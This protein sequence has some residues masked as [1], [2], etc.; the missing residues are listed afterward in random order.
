MKK[1]LYALLAATVVL[2]AF[3][4]LNNSLLFAEARQKRPVLLAHRGMAQSFSR[5]GL[6]NDTCTATRIF[7]PEHA[8]L[9]NTIASM[10]AAFDAGADIVE[11]DVQPTT[12]GAFAVFHDWTVDC[13]TEGKGVTREHSLAQLKALDVGYGYTADGGKTFPF[14]GKGVG[15]MPSL[16]E[17]LT[18]FPDKRFLI[19]IK[20]ND[21]TEGN[22][23]A[24]RLARLPPGQR[25]L[26][27]VYGAHRPI[28]ALH[29]RLP[30]IPVGSK[31]T[32]KSCIIRY[33]AVGWT[34]YVPESCREGI[35]LVP[36]NVA[37]WMWGWPSRYLERMEKANVNVFVA[38][39]Y[40]GGASGGV[41]DLELLA[42]LPED[43]AG[44]IWTDRIE[45]IAPAVRGPAR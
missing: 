4:Y 13:R 37:P 2:A 41:N 12:D 9:E 24:E 8:Y 45:R 25:A 43:Y 40:E 15:L 38:G 20:S 28:A 42:Q 21:V 22:L 14:R 18:A 27:M 17:V 33:F 36:L 31:R 39:P 16:D 6:E 7:P 10:Q 1:I 32:M 26:L 34:G 11:F 44:G 19:N 23:L 35:M 5:D 3:V 30:E 29:A